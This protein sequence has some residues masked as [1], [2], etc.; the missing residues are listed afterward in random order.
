MRVLIVGSLDLRY[1]NG[2]LAAVYSL[3]TSVLH[4]I[5]APDLPVLYDVAQHYHAF[6]LILTEHRFKVLLRLFQGPLGD[7]YALILGTGYPVSIDITLV[8][9]LTLQ[10]NTT[11]LI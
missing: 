3:N 8:M 10:N 7:D 2:V 4:I 11:V 5:K 9:I 6:D 1:L